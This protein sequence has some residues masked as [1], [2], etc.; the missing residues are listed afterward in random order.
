MKSQP[1]PT[2]HDDPE[3]IRSEINTT[4]HRMDETIDAL[5][6]RL[7]GR[8]LL[9]EALHIFRKQQ[10]NGN[11][12]KFKNRLT[13]S[14][15]TAYHSVVDT[16][17]TH[18]IPAAL[19][20]AGVGWLI[21]ERTHST[22][23][24]GNEPADIGTD[25][26]VRPYYN[27]FSPGASGLGAQGA[28]CQESA[29]SSIGA[30]ASQAMETIQHKASDLGERVRETGMEA[31]EGARRL[32][33]KSRERVTTAV[34]DHPLESGL[35]FLA[36]GLIASLLIPTPR[37]LSQR[38]E[39]KARE[40]SERVRDKAQDLVE[41]GS[42]VV[43]SATQAAKQEAKAQGL[44]GDTTAGTTQKEA[45]ETRSIAKEATGERTRTPGAIS[46][47]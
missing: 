8:H 29:S 34:E 3:T 2:H 27:E 25:R 12:T 39:P 15:D 46:A 31:K 32:Y 20:G 6:Q 30:K 23:D 28:G 45:P 35:V 40:L 10:E 13:E 24:S 17:K 47:P 37:R 4:R 26:G 38:L 41:R 22:S 5:G 18:P 14:A 9:D 11:M 1:D 19:F 16:I 42:H 43:E 36:A 33:D 7:K 44:T 21:Y